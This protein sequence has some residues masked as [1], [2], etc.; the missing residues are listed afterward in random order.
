MI[1]AYG[2]YTLNIIEAKTNTEGGQTSASAITQNIALYL[3]ETHTIEKNLSCTIKDS[4]MLTYEKTTGKIVGTKIGKTTLTCEQDKT[5]INYNIEIIKKEKTLQGKVGTTTEIVDLNCK[6]TDSSIVKVDTNNQSITLNAMK[7]GNTV[8]TCDNAIYNYGV[9]AADRYTKNISIRKGEKYDLGDKNCTSQDPK[10][11]IS[12]DKTSVVFD[13]IG[14]NI[15]IKCDNTDF[16]ATVSEINEV[17]RS[18][19]NTFYQFEDNSCSITKGKDLVNESSMYNKKGL[20]CKAAGVVEYA[21]NQG[22]NTYTVECFDSSVDEAVINFAFSKNSSYTC[23]NGN[24]KLAKRGDQTV[25]FTTIDN[26]SNPTYT[27]SCKVREENGVSYYNKYVGKMQDFTQDTF[28]QSVSMNFV[29]NVYVG[30]VV[31]LKFNNYEL[32]KSNVHHHRITVMDANRK[33]IK[34]VKNSESLSF[35]ITSEMYKKYIYIEFEGGGFLEFKTLYVN[36]L[37]SCSLTGVNTPTIKDLKANFDFT[38]EGSCEL[39]DFTI[40]KGSCVSDYKASISGDKLKI[41][42]NLYDQSCSALFKVEDPNYDNKSAQI[43]VSKTPVNQ[44][45]VVEKYS[46]GT[47][48]GWNKELPVGKSRTIEILLGIKGSHDAYDGSDALK[49]V[50]MEVLTP[51]IISISN[52]K[53]TGLKVGVGKIKFTIKETSQVHEVD[54]TVVDEN[55]KGLFT[56][57]GFQ[58]MINTAVGCENT[59]YPLLLENKCYAKQ[60]KEK[61]ESPSS[62]YK[63]IGENCVAVSDYETPKFESKP[64]GDITLS[65]NMITNYNTTYT[66]QYYCSQSCNVANISDCTQS[67]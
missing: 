56:C 4:K 31:E 8:I 45:E 24:L 53:V 5:K 50:S 6:A 47:V 10:A 39:N 64:S 43:N 57:Y 37:D 13:E 33:V 58:Q 62:N 15:K 54:V 28:K 52:K 20:Y 41:D 26:S 63:M 32:L 21:C 36:K 48:D 40:F 3:N 17:K 16:I 27:A 35:E 11:K 42:A 66:S 55:K 34:E 59:N 14:E 29:N 22:K 38:F 65:E 46:F 9:Q 19:L 2:N 7:V 67:K 60:P 1:C 25:S 51:D 18:E 12:D 23:E 49:R 61:C 30:A 44:E